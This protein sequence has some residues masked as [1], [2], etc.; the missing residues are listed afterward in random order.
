MEAVLPARIELAIAGY[1]AA[2]IPF[3]YGSALTLSFK[4]RSDQQRKP[5]SAL[6][7]RCRQSL[8]THPT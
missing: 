7:Q 5:V 3:N 4:S 8:Q 6:L 1:K 2:V